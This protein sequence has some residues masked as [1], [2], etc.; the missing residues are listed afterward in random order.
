MNGSIQ[1][2][3][4]WEKNFI[5]YSIDLKR[6]IGKDCHFRIDIRIDKEG[7]MNPKLYILFHFTPNISIFLAILKK[8]FT[9]LLS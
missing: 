9:Q 5:H 2:Q 4:Q 3:I 7:R 1:F 8:A 6:V